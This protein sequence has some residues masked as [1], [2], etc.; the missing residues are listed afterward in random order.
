M[1]AVVLTPIVYSSVRWYLIEVYYTN[2]QKPTIID[3]NNKTKSELYKK[4]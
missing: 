4:L 2:L 1:Y 3:T